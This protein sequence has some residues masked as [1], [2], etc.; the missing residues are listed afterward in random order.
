MADGPFS[1]YLPEYAKRLG[2]AHQ[3]FEP[4]VEDKTRQ[5]HVK[6]LHEEIE[7]L[8]KGVMEFR[9]RIMTLGQ[10]AMVTLGLQYL[11]VGLK[12][13]DRA[14]VKRLQSQAYAEF[15]PMVLQIHSLGLE[16]ALEA[17]NAR[18]FGGHGEDMLRSLKDDNILAYSL[19]RQ[20]REY[21]DPHIRDNIKEQIC[22]DVFDSLVGLSQFKRTVATMPFIKNQSDVNKICELVDQVCRYIKAGSSS[23]ALRADL[24]PR[25]QLREL[26]LL[27]ES[28]T[29]NR[30]ITDKKRSEDEDLAR[31]T[32]DGLLITLMAGIAAQSVAFVLPIA[33]TQPDLDT[34]ASMLLLSAI[35]FAVCGVLSQASA[36]RRLTST[37]ALPTAYM[38]PKYI[39]AI[40]HKGQAFGVSYTLTVFILLKQQKV[41]VHLSASSG[42]SSPS[43]AYQHLSQCSHSS[44]AVSGIGMRC[45]T[46]DQNGVDSSDTRWK[47]GRRVTVAHEAAVQ[48]S[49]YELK[50]GA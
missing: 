14:L 29:K 47:R 13:L 22:V 46:Q 23:L 45:I 32:Q 2:R 12:Y 7:K 3:H 1:S 20:S 10:S 6:E 49:A 28:A 8:R 17:L 37:T 40:A 5:Q 27:F 44:S 36:Y 35:V 21:Y 24:A 31:I 9:G 11:D 25:P 30:C 34:I 50:R 42:F 33:S 16:K 41:T 4:S 26:K 48:I 19:M 39:T 43:F 18:G 15:Y 38:K